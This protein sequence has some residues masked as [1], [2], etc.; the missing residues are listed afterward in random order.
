MAITSSNEPIVMIPYSISGVNTPR[1]FIGNSSGS[2]W[3]SPITLPSD[4]LTAIGGSWSNY[5]PYINDMDYD[6]ISDSILIATSYNGNEGL[7]AISRTGTLRWKTTN[8]WPSKSGTYRLGVEVP[9]TSAECRIV[10]FRG[11]NGTGTDAGMARINSNGGEIVTTDY[12]GTYD[13]TRGYAACLVPPS[14]SVPNWR[15][16]GGATGYGNAYYAYLNL[17]SSF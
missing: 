8:I 10:V 6:P 2:S 3:G 9:K 15:F 16:F 13:I 12:S 7:F 1:I 5:N 14:G 11:D 4:V 17:P